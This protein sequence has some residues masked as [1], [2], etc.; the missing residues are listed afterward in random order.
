MRKP[1]LAA[2]MALLLL[3]ACGGSRWNPLNWFG[4]S[5]EVA[6]AQTGPDGGP[7]AD[8]RPLVDQVLSMTVERYSGGAIVRATGL[9]PTQGFWDG[10]LVAQ[11]IE[12]GRLT[13]RFILYPPIEPTRVSTQA[14]REVT[15]GASVSQIT[16][17]KISEIVVQGAN[18]A[19]SSRR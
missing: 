6:V 11:P 4:G 15:A 1:L 16:L 10:K 7:P 12:K 13:Y 18:N 14:S 9:P 5:R 8:T 19:R 17:D 3:A 2:L